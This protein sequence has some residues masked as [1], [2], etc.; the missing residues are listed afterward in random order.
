[1][2]KE[3]TIERILEEIEACKIRIANAL[4]KLEQTKIIASQDPDWDEWVQV[5]TESLDKWEAHL[6]ALIKI[7][8]EV[9][10][11]TSKLLSL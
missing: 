10:N 9:K 7:L 6:S 8:E 5:D 11:G 4:T 1:M 3:T 2:T